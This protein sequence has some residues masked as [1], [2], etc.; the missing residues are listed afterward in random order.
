M[1]EERRRQ[2]LS[3]LDRQGRVTVDDLIR[4]F[5]VSAVTGRADLDRLAELGALVRSH[6]GAVK[7]EGPEM[8][9]PLAYKKTVHQTE[10]DRIGR[11]AAE[12]VQPNQIVLLDSGTTTVAVARHIKLRHVRPLTVIT[13][14]IDIALELSSAPQVSVV[15]LGG[16]LRPPSLST[17]GPQS[18]QTLMHLN[19]DQLFLGVDGLDPEIGLTTPDILEA[20]LGALMVRISKTINVVADSS[21]FGNRSLSVIAKMES[22]HR[23]VTDTGADPKIVA[24]IRSHGVEVIT[25]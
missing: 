3:L 14:A 16:I 17:V 2:I 9:F 7:R 20:Q 23:V 25:A 8:D 5:G 22:V 6:G 10:K 19:A 1:A 13:N 15:V 24:A 12:V 11:A 21:K 4:Q 18:V